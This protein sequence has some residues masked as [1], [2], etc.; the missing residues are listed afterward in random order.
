LQVNN[1]NKN[2]FLEKL[3]Y[4]KLYGCIQKQIDSFLQGFEE[5]IPRDLISIFTPN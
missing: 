5:L 2:Q 4:Y 1:E 3:I